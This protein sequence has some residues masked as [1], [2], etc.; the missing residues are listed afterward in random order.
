MRLLSLL[1]AFFVAA[2]AHA[3]E[4]HFRII[5]LSPHLTE[6][7]FSS[8]AGQ[9]L[10]GVDTYSNYPE[11]VKNLPKVGDAF[12]LNIE[13][14]LALKPDLVL[15]WQSS[16]KPKD[17]KR[18][19]ALGL[20]VFVSNIQTLDG[21]PREIEEIG[22]LAGTQ[23]HAY[24]TAQALRRDLSFLKE[25]YSRKPPI[26]YFYQIWNQPL[27]TINGQLFISQGLAL[28]GAQ[29][30]FSDLAPI[31]PQ[32]NRESVLMKNPQVIFL[33]GGSVKDQDLWWRQWWKFPMLKAVKHK[34]VIGVN[35]DL[36]QRPT[37]RFIKALPNLCRQ[38]DNARRVYM[39]H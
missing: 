20:Q 28:C 37:E 15:V 4:T 22:Y 29:N 13:Q 9:D 11:T 1:L 18:L 30:V 33:G 19:K 25:T 14:I 7:T 36:Y 34:E 2:T 32:V 38:I 5:S 39:S 35:G 24:E 23:K 3:E 31:A 16:I 12:H 21:I 17:L 27:T 6:M 26:T 8:G 10:V